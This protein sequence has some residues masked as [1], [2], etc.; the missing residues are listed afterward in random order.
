VP[1][2]NLLKQNTSSAGHTALAF[3]PKILVRVLLVVLVLA[4][5]YYGWLF[6]RGG[7]V[8]KDTA[9]L[10][11]KMDNESNAA[12]SVPRLNELLTRQL[13]IK[14]LQ[15][16]VASHIY[17]SRLFSEL[18]RVTL[19]TASYDSMQVIGDGTIQLNAE[20]PSIQDLDKYLQVF[21][22]TDFNKYFSNVRVSQFTKIQSA[23]LGTTGI[24]FQIKMQ[25]D[26]S[27]IS[28]S[29]AGTN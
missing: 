12:T 19:K 11:A 14:D 21:D 4:L 2:I 3:A 20:V 6:Y 9:S 29:P 8:T 26:P 16:V 23:A 24:Q 5:G 10:Q 28:Y 18:A 15:G 1:Q 13:Q 25:Y 7:S 22:L 17:W 27:L